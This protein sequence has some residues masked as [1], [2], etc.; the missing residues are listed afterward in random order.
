MLQKAPLNLKSSLHLSSTSLRPVL[1]S[2]SPPPCNLSPLPS[3]FFH[4]LIFASFCLFP[5]GYI[6]PLSRPFFPPSPFPWGRDILNNSERGMIYK[7]A[8]SVQT[9]QS[10][11]SVWRLITAKERRGGLISNDTPLFPNWCTTSAQ[12]V[13]THPCKQA[14]RRMPGHD[15]SLRMLSQSNSQA[16]SIS[17][18]NIS[19]LSCEKLLEVQVWWFKC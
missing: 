2:S 12:C 16:Q 14:L 4:S 7:S 18:R 1:A 8:C 19:L 17:E 6:F 13:Q 5:G 10:R 11:S 9:S 3:L 15:L